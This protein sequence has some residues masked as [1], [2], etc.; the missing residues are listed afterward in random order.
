M[1]GTNKIDT[2][3]LIHAS[4]G[5]IALVLGGL[6]FNHTWAQPLFA[7]LML[8]SAVSAVWISWRQNAWVTGHWLAM[9]PVVGVF[10][11]GIGPAWGYTV[12]YSCLWLAF[13]HFLY[14]GYQS[15]RAQ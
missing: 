8:L 11:G 5:I 6:M 1:A 7:G 9:L 4:A 3:A 12:A 14:R 10:I 13:V 2:G 15:S